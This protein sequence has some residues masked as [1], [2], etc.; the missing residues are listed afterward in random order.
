MYPS[1]L[2]L[3]IGYLNSVLDLIQNTWVFLQLDKTLLVETQCINFTPLVKTLVECVF[4]CKL[5]L[6]K[7]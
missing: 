7:F 3:S 6:N 5:S 4:P 1:G 2:F